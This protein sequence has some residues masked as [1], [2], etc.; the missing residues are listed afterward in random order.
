M[1][2]AK[3]FAAPEEETMRARLLAVVWIGLFVLSATLL[4]IASVSP[5]T[6]A[7]IP[8]LGYVDAAAAFA[9]VVLLAIFERQRR[10]LQVQDLILSLGIIGVVLPAMFVGLWLGREGIV[11]NTL[12]P[13]LAWRS[14]VLLWGLPSVI[15]ALRGR[16]A[17]GMRRESESGSG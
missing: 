14:F 7:Q 13:G 16:G 4:G 2:V 9:L 12:L 6:V 1:E 8:T 11:W 17:I 10:T 3:P 5:E 15:A